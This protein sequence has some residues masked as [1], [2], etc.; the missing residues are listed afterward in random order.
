MV[1]GKSETIL[2]DTAGLPLY[3]Y[4]PDTATIWFPID[5]TLTVFLGSLLTYAIGSLLMGAFRDQAGM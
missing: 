4:A 3:Y 5:I 2:V 1:S